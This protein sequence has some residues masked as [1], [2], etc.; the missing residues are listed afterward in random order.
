MSKDSDIT[1]EWF[2]RLLM[3][4]HVDMPMTFRLFTNI[5]CLTQTFRRFCTNH[6]T[7]LFFTTYFSCIRRFSECPSSEAHASSKAKRESFL[8]SDSC[9]G[10][11]S[12]LLGM[13]R[14]SVGSSAFCSGTFLMAAQRSQ[15]RWSLL[16]GAVLHLQLLLWLQ[17]LGYHFPE[18]WMVPL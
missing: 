4:I 16:A 7:L 12:P 18:R 1:S 11:V 6:A 13:L 5:L 9:N 3:T 2:L 15:L 17:P 14:S 8:R 10:S